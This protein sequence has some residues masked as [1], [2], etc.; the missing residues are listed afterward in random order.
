MTKPWERGKPP[1]LEG[2]ADA[3]RLRAAWLRVRAKGSAGGVDGV[4]VADSR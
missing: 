1:T 3:D 2:A 4:A